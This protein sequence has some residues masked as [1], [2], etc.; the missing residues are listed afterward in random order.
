M[1]S[2]KAN[3]LKRHKKNYPDMRQILDINYSPNAMMLWKIIKNK[4]VDDDKID[5]R[6]MNFDLID[7]YDEDDL[8]VDFNKE[9]KRRLNT[10]DV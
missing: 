4:L 8:I 1:K 9:H 5:C 6:G 7:E 2:G 10:K 3:A